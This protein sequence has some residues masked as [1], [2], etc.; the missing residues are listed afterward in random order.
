MHEHYVYF[1][2]TR[3][4][5]VFLLKIKRIIF[6]GFCCQGSDDVH[7]MGTVTSCCFRQKNKKIKLWFY[8]IWLLKKLG[9]QKLGTVQLLE[10]M[11]AVQTLS[12][13]SRAWAKCRTRASEASITPRST[14]EINSFYV[15]TYWTTVSTASICTIISTVSIYLYYCNPLFVLLCL[16]HIFVLL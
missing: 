15:Y 5:G 10:N 2:K 14:S 3:D 16:Q 6:C 8:Q 7:E 11:Q 9:C 4:A 1:R 13:G 12:N